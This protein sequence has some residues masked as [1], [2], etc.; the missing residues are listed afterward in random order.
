MAVYTI[1]NV[2]DLQDMWQHL[3][4]DCV[5]V[6]DIDATDTKFWNPIG[7]TPPTYYEGFLPIDLIAKRNGLS[8]PANIFTG[9]FD[10]Q[11]FTID[12]LYINQPL[13]GLSGVQGS[14][15]LFGFSTLGVEVRNVNM[16]N[17]DYSGRRYIG[18]FHGFN[19]GSVTYENINVD[20]IIRI[21]NVDATIVY[22]GGIC[23]NHTGIMNDCNANITIEYINS[24]PQRSNRHGGI[25]GCVSGSA[26]CNRCNG[27]LTL[28]YDDEITGLGG[29]GYGGFCGSNLGINTHTFNNCTGVL[30][31]TMTAGNTMGSG[32]LIS[33][34]GFRGGY[35]SGATGGQDYNYCWGKAN[36]I[37]YGE[38]RCQCGGFVGTRGNSEVAVECFAIANIDAPDATLAPLNTFD[39]GGFSG[40][41]GATDCWADGEL[42][43]LGCQCPNAKIGGFQGRVSGSNPN[44]C[45][46]LTKVHT[47]T[48]GEYGGLIGFGSAATDSHWDTQ[49]SGLSNGSGSD[50]SPTG[51]TG[52]TTTE[53]KTRS[54]YE[55]SW[56]FDVV[57]LLPVY[58]RSGTGASNLT[59]WFSA[60]GDYDNFDEGT[61]D[62]DAFSTVLPTSNEIQWLDSL[63]DLVVGT[64]A[65]E[66]IIR[67][68]D[69]DSPLTPSNF[70]VRRQTTFGSTRVQSIAVNDAIL[71]VDFVGR[72]V[73]ELSY[74]DE[75][76]K[77][78]SN[79]LTELA[80]HIT[81]TGVVE[82]AHQ[83]NPESTLWSV[84]NNGTLLSLFYNREQQIIAWSRHLIGGS[85]VVQSVLVAPVE[86]GEDE[87]W[88]S[89][90]RT[91][92]GNPK[93]YIEKFAPREWGTDNEDA[94]FVDSG[95]QY[96]GPATGT[97]TGLNHLIG[98]TVGV[99]GDGKIYDEQIV[100]G[101]G[102]I[103]IE[104]NGTPE[105]V[106]KAQV[107]LLSEYI[108]QPTRIV[109]GGENTTFG[110][111]QRINDLLIRF[112]RS[113]DVDYGRDLTALY[114]VEILETEIF[115]G[116]I[117][118]AVDGGFTYDSP[119]VI[120]GNG[121]GPCSI[122]ALI[123]DLDVTG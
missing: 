36:I 100:N 122:M 35:I 19:N 55:V 85:G 46:S 52:N 20:G 80:E 102:Q 111:E 11:G 6:G 76:G 34:G 96:S 21:I 59:V 106:E 103:P 116:D 63:E 71:H 74:S 113:I 123:V 90:K 39:I 121:P 114:P 61:E 60:S 109:F 47:D 98:E 104:L 50:P 67:S 2:N 77:Y 23:G 7:G 32:D 68:N 62:S 95:I 78:A 57:W 41:L 91:I 43:K 64:A 40:N 120:T 31:L 30:N 12:G 28:E 44:R 75:Q 56:D 101:S 45:Y 22:F 94:Y 112:D 3:A 79:D 93:V 38:V 53:M 115:S 37:L 5:L 15:G 73:R 97:I 83:K 1:S 86:D 69:L 119:I 118:V 70:S 72:K 51:M 89:V 29:G 14:V 99:W 25:A 110:L 42:M 92:N 24:K 48:V 88:I 10:G 49:T 65:G 4:D 17:F 81:K 27:T 66:W 9:T 84:L 108:F 58:I 26:V 54:T 107:G 105:T 82:T 13:D 18:A 33:A 8:P 87:V 117:K 16:T